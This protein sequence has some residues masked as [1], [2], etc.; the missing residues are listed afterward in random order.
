MPKLSFARNQSEGHNFTKK[1]IPISINIMIMMI[2]VMI[3]M[4]IMMIIM[5][6][7]ITRRLL[8]RLTQ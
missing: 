4:M 8:P 6:I 1:R 2:I 5:M 3:I 7:M